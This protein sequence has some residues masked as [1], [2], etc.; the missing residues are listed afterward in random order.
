MAESKRATG[1]DPGR[2]AAA[3]GQAARAAR[4]PRAASARPAAEHD[5]SSAAHEQP[6]EDGDGSASH[7]AGRDGVC[8]VAFCP[9]CT[10][11]SV[12]NRASP[13]V[14]QHLLLAGQQFLMALKAVVDA[15]AADFEEPRAE[16][17]PIQRIDIA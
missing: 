4:G 2:T 7:E 11:V 10:A 8:P 1:G 16:E 15:R 12:V 14:V 5:R 3:T 9:I 13:D 6:R 17:T